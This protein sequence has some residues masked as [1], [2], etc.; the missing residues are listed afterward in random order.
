VAY[1]EYQVGQHVDG[2]VWDA[3]CDVDCGSHAGVNKEKWIQV[4]CR[5]Q[6]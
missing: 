5:I 4:C 2:A 3:G 1:A 6:T